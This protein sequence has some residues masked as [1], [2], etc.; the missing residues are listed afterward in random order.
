MTERKISNVAITGSVVAHVLILLCLFYYPYRTTADRRVR[1]VFTLEYRIEAVAV[2]ESVPGVT[3]TG[4]GLQENAGNNDNRRG[5]A[6]NSRPDNGK[7]AGKRQQNAANGE[8]RAEAA[9]GQVSTPE[10][11]RSNS[12]IAVDEFVPARQRGNNSLPDIDSLL[13]VET[14]AAP[15]RTPE[16]MARAEAQSVV[17]ESGGEAAGERAGGAG[18]G[19]RLAGDSAGG[20]SGADGEGG[21]GGVAGGGRGEGT[22]HG[23]GAEAGINPCPQSMVHIPAGAESFCIDRYEYPNREDGIPQGGVQAAEAESYCRSRGKRLCRDYEWER[24]CAGLAGRAYPY[25]NRYEPRKCNAGQGNAAPSGSH[26]MCVSD[27]HVYDLSGNLAEWVA[28]G[29][30]SDDHALMGGS[31]METGRGTACPSRKAAGGA[32]D[33]DTAGFRCCK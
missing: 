19:M 8:A 13:G 12:G 3:G 22:G 4:G 1:P 24:A 29:V 18:A 17:P 6:L 31:Y 7:A 27:Y 20:A 2:A 25:G 11:T 33:I 14:A 23:E 16:R 30:E 28:T 21:A 5:A 15:R 9:R 10:H 26:K 32:D